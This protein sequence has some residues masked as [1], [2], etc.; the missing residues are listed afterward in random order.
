MAREVIVDDEDL[1]DLIR[2]GCHPLPVDLNI[3]TGDIK[4]LVSTYW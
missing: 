2:D 3:S 1:Y 4:W